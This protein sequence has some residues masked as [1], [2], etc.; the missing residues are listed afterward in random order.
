MEQISKLPKRSSDALTAPEL[1]DLEKAFANNASLDEHRALLFKLFTIYKALLEYFAKHKKIASTI[2]RLLGF[3]PSSERTGQDD[4]PPLDRYSEER[5]RQLTERQRRH[6]ERVQA[7]QRMIDECVKQIKKRKAQKKRERAAARKAAKEAAAQSQNTRSESDNTEAEQESSTGAPGQEPVPTEPF[8]VEQNEGLSEELVFSPAA[9]QEQEV[10][11]EL[12]VNTPTAPDPETSR[13]SWD[14]RTRHSLSLV[15]TTHK[16]RVE[17]R[18][19]NKTGYSETAKVTHGPEGYQAT[20][21][22]IAQLS[23]MVAGMLIP[24]NRLG[25]SLKGKSSH[26]F[27]AP[28]ILRLCSYAARALFPIYPQ[29]F[30]ELA[31]CDHLGGDDTNSAV[32]GMRKDLPNLSPEELVK[33]AR[34]LEESLAQTDPQRKNVLLEAEQ[35]LGAQ[36]NRKDGKGKKKSV[37]CS[38]VIGRNLGERGSIVFYHTER[39]SLGDLLSRILRERASGPAKLKTVRLQSDGLS[40]NKPHGLPEGL[41]IR[42]AGC[43]AHARRPFWRMRHDLDE[44]VSRYCHEML[45]CF[46][47]IFASDSEARE[48][49]VEALLRAREEVQRP[50][51]EEIRQ[52]AEDIIAEFAPNSPMAEA[53]RYIRTHYDALILYLKDPLLMPDNNRSERALRHEKLMLGGSGFRRSREG[54]LYWDILRTAL[55]TCASLG[56]NQIEY[57][58]HCLRNQEDVTKHPERYTPRAYLKRM[59]EAQQV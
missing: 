30:K 19:C 31:L 23:V 12:P 1:L 29:M 18:V 49:G 51:W 15:I 56:V 55:A 21:G 52:F 27:T 13:S 59:Q 45:Y 34:E 48:E 39:K 9:A 26:Y 8:G 58:E 22:A 36:M 35:F 57:L 54:R 43:A 47:Q 11:Q 2:Q 16:L 33:R 25:N 53:A 10:E 41:D 28:T 3:V 14:E 24:I 37:L 46:L 20:W 7:L 17:T 4:K 5:L 50:L 6:A 42:Y 40:G 32:L 38:V 44:A